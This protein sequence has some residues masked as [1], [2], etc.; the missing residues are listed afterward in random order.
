MN[1][2]VGHHDILAL[3]S[4]QVEGIYSDPADS[5]GRLLVADWFPISLT[6]FIPTN[7]AQLQ[8]R[9]Q[10][11]PVLS[12][13]ARLLATCCLL[14]V[15]SAPTVEPAVTRT[16]NLCTPAG[17]GRT[18]VR[19]PLGFSRLLCNRRRPGEKPNRFYC[20]QWYLVFAFFLRFPQSLYYLFY[21]FFS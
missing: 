12:L 2:A 13:Q 20:Q 18:G 5:S 21:F 11:C 6:S 17:Q 4:S 9:P 14:A 8:V 10:S 3:V 7:W 19:T 16:F 1:G 15:V